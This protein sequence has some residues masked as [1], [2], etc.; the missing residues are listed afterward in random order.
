MGAFRDGAEAEGSAPGP[1][2]RVGHLVPVDDAQNLR[3]CEWI[4]ELQGPD[5]QH[6]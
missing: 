4:S 6:I 1:M 2:W 3:L 5:G